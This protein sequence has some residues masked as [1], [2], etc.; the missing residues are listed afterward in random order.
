MNITKINDTISKKNIIWISCTYLY[1]FEDFEMTTQQRTIQ[2]VDSMRL[3]R[4][5]SIAVEGIKRLKWATTYMHRENGF[6]QANQKNV[7]NW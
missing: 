2:Y 6:T 7:S 5:L 3:L 1:A 4:F